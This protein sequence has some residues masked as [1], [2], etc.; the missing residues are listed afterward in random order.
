MVTTVDEE[1]SPFLG[2]QNARATAIEME[3]TMITENDGVVG[4]NRPRALRAHPVLL[5][6]H[7]QPFRI[8]RLAD[9]RLTLNPVLVPAPPTGPLRR[10]P[11]RR[12]PRGADRAHRRVFHPAPVERGSPAALVVLRQLEIE[13]LAVHPDC[14]VADADPGVE[15]GT[16]GVEGAV[17]GRRGAG[18]AD[19]R[20]EE[21]A[22]VVEHG[23]LDDV[24]RPQEQ[25][26]RDRQAQRLG[27]LEIDDQLE[28]GRLLDGEIGSLRSFNDTSTPASTNCRKLCIVGR[29]CWRTSVA[30]CFGSMNHKS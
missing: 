4:G 20:T 6:F 13:A 15:P 22:A 5:P 17:V 30:T 11:R 27:G 10:L 23:L 18:R 12:L 16:E 21:S 7:L 28:L 29:R 9:R 8:S 24:V 14:N 26:L 1:K 3:Q 2:A 19:C 25:R